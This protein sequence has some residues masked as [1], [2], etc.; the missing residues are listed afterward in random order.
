MSSGNPLFWR[1]PWRSHPNAG[2]PTSVSTGKPYRGINVALL[3]WAANRFNWSSKFW[4][5]YRQW[6]SLGGQVMPRPDDVERGEWGATAVLYKPI[7]KTRVVDGEEVD[8]SFFLLKTFKLF[9]AQQVLGVE[10]FQVNESDLTGD[11]PAA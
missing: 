10:Q 3:Q 5:T 1:R 11:V 2:R 7:T 4:A 9:N 6:E 8:E